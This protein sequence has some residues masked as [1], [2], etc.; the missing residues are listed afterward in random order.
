MT[1]LKAQL[2]HFL[3]YLRCCWEIPKELVS[4]R[5]GILHYHHPDILETLGSLAPEHKL[6]ELIETALFSSPA[7]GSF[8]GTAAE[9]EHEL[10][11]EGSEVRRA[12]S[13]LRL[14]LNLHE[15]TLRSALRQF[16][17]VILPI[18]CPSSV[19]IWSGQW[20]PPVS[21]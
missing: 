12:A 19:L 7:P 1:A 13:Q 17:S 18:C 5:Y 9:L 14:R 21:A 2:P 16:A 4:Q 11:K 20:I 3:Y 10:T 8:E 15:H 6:L